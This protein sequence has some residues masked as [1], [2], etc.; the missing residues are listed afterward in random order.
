MATEFICSIRATG[1]D[2]PT[3]SLWEAAVQTDL[4]A[5]TT[6]VFAHGG[7]TGTVGDGA[8]VT[9]V[10]ST[11]TGLVK[12][13]SATQILIEVTGGTFV[14][15]EVVQVSAGNSVTISDAGASA[16]AVAE[17]YDDWASGLSDYVTVD[18]WITTYPGSK[19][20]IRAVSGAENK[21]IKGAGFYISTSYLY[22]SAIRFRVN[23]DV[24]DIEARLTSTSTVNAAIKCDA[25]VTVHTERTLAYSA[26]SSNIFQGSSGSPFF[27]N[28]IAFG[29]GANNG[30]VDAYSKS[31]FKNC[32]AVNCGAGFNFTTYNPV[33]SNCIAYANTTSY[34]GT[35]VPTGSNNA[36]S[37]AASVTPPGTSPLLTNVTSSDFVNAAGDDY[38]LASGAILIG[39]GANL[40]TDFTD[41]IDGDTRPSTGAWDIGV[42]HYVST[43]GARSLTASQT[44][45]A[46]SNSAT[47]KAL[48]QL[49]ASQAITAFASSA[50]LAVLGE[51]TANQTIPAFASAGVL[52]SKN[53][54]T[55]SNT[56]ADFVAAAALKVHAHL[57]GASTIP[58]VTQAA[59][60]KVLAKATGSS[61]VP[62]FL[63]AAVVGTVQRLTAAQQISDFASIG[64][65]SNVSDPGVHGGVYPRWR[66]IGRR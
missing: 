60:V 29:S 4:T 1:G 36:A 39:A 65:L 21:G 32:V 6:L 15:G 11:A 43:G 66:R 45:A 27:Y 35:G 10:T 13:A 41:D 31:T 24:L 34:S 49:M 23:G 22:S 57:N 2:Y 3:L 63:S 19:A 59:V 30:F 46:F 17:C 51:L 9:G 55:A 38:H 8:G 40:T 14:S 42:D 64:V 16:H 37:D 48:A 33:I 18:G 12:H 50:A 28:C 52:S 47:L 5:A 61:V 56:L 54:L 44:I 26:S 58:A 25:A 53:N 62:E 20:I 7:I